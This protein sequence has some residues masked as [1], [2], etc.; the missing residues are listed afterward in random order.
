M[1]TPG[2][3]R[4]IGIVTRR[5]LQE[6]AVQIFSAIYQNLQPSVSATCTSADDRLFFPDDK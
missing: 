3:A 6:R 1:I 4:G 5:V 2:D